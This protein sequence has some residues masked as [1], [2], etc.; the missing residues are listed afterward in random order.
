MTHKFYP[1]SQISAKK[2]RT[3]LVDRYT[4]KERD[5]KALEELSKA[6]SPFTKW[7]KWGRVTFTSNGLK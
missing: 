6:Q 1:L 5:R 2:L 7:D 4:Q 3:R